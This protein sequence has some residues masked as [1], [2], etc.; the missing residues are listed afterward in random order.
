MVLGNYTKIVFTS[1]NHTS[2]HVLVT[3]LGP[4]SEQCVGLTENT[5]FFDFM[6][7]ALDIEHK[8][9]TMSY[10]EARRHRRRPNV[11]ALEMYANLD[12]IDLTHQIPG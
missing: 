9:P 6:L 4:A 3:A 2:E 10:D 11:Q 8:N 12:A 5:A 7:A 1:G